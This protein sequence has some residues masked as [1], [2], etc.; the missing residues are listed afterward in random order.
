M[1]ILDFRNQFSSQQLP[2]SLSLLII[3]YFLFDYILTIW[4]IW[5]KSD[6][7]G[8]LKTEFVKICV[9]VTSSLLTLKAVITTIKWVHILQMRKLFS[10]LMSIYGKQSND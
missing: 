9:P 8:L 10:L 7:T 6:F 1:N 3:I 2:V 5:I 4:K